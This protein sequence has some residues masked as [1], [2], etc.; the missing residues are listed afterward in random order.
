MI[1][2]YNT[3]T[4]TNRDGKVTDKRGTRRILLKK[5][6]HI[7]L[8]NGNQRILEYNKIVDI[9]TKDDK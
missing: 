7:E 5:I 4:T 6:Y 2:K 1:N 3:L 8:E 9:P